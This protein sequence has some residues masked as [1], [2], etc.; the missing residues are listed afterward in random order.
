MKMGATTIRITEDEAGERLD[1]FLSAYYPDFSRSKLQKLIQEDVILINLKSAKNSYKLRENDVITFLSTTEEALILAQEL[2][3]EVVYED[4]DMLVVNK[5]KNMLTHPTGKEKSGTLVN[6][7]LHKCPELSDI[8][9]QMRR[10]IVHRLDRNTT[11]LLIVAKNNLAHEFFSAQIKNREITKKYLAV[12]HGVVTDDE[13][14]INAPIGR[15]LKH[16][17]KMCV[18]SE[19]KPSVTKFK[20]LERF[21]NQTYL[22][23]D[24]ITGRTHQIR[25]HL[26]SIGHPIVNDSLYSNAK[27]KVKTTEQ[28]LQSYSL[29]FKKMFDNNMITIEI[30]PDETIEKVLKYLRSKK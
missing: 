12:V 9:G 6:A 24:L 18:T 5:P 19:G 29:T 20:V 28:V 17:E 2:P 11:G 15:N 13:G 25:V 7:L 10:G 3:I 21:E 22:E 14:E 16:P 30:P 23:L 27:F 1:L 8:N 4:E 26:S